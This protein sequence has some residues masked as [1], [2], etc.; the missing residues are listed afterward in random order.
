[1]QNTRGVREHDF[2]R[3]QE[4]LGTQWEQC[5]RTELQQVGQLLV[6]GRMRKTKKPTMVVVPPGV[7]VGCQFTLSVRNAPVC[8][9]EAEILENLQFAKTQGHSRY[10]Q[11]WVD[12]GAGD[13]ILQV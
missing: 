3:G 7:R 4:H 11:G 8:R 13:R 1:M 5:K 6:G 9:D 12:R 2:H 10:P